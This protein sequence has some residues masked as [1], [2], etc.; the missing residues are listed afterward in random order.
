LLLLQTPTPIQDEPL[1]LPAIVYPAEAKSLHIQGAVQL[2][3]DVD[4][5]GHVTAVHALAGPEK[6]RQA[7]I[8]AYSQATYRPVISKGH[9]TPAII[10]TTVNFNLAEAPPVPAEAL[11]KRFQSQ[12][13]TCQQLSLLRDPQALTACMQAVETARGMAAGA[14]LEARAAAFN[15]LV[16]L[17][18]AD[19]KKSKHLP[20]AGRYADQAVTLVSGSSVH[21]PAIATAYI[22]RAEV[23]SLAGNLKGAAADCATAE[24]T[25]QTLIAD[26][27]E[28]EKAGGYRS[29]MRELIELHALILERD[30]KK[31]Q[32]RD[33]RQRGA[34]LAS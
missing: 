33:L 7:A 31:D 20:E 9:P 34:L 17:L 15:D 21:Q 8:D 10:T 24:E 4:P 27:G 25:L 1:T 22:T 5:T 14:E 26:E 32:A 3:I 29:Q 18:I 11:G 2:Q 12:H 19:G 13:A 16:L 6:L 30:G 28:N 23:R